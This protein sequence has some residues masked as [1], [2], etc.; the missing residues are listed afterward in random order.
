MSVFRTS[1]SSDYPFFLINAQ[2]GTDASNITAG[3]TY[4][5]MRYPTYPD[6]DQTTGDANAETA[7]LTGIKTALQNHDWTADYGTGVSLQAFHV[8]R[9]DESLTDVSPA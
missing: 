6:S 9:Y 7:L 2:I 3:F 5:V 8:T 4:A 1:Q